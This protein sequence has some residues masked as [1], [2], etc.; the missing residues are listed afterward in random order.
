MRKRVSG[1]ATAASTSHGIAPSDLGSAP[2]NGTSPIGTRACEVFV[3]EGER[4]AAQRAH[5]SSVLSQITGGGT[6]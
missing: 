3:A 4:P 5:F 6:A 2:P 1:I